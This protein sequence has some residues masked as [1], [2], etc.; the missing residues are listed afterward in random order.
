MRTC[1]FQSRKLDSADVAGTYLATP[2]VR[3]LVVSK[4]GS[5]QNYDRL[6]LQGINLQDGH[7]EDASFIAADLSGATL[8]KANLCRA[9]LVQTQL[10]H[11]D[12]TS[13]CLTGAYIQDWAIATDTKLEQVEANTSTRDCRQKTIPILVVNQITNRKTLNLE[14]FL[15]LLHQSSKLSIFI[16]SKTSIRVLLRLRRLTYTII[17]ESILMQLRLR[18]SN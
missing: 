14:T 16:A 15:I 7:L 2:K 4:D 3:Q 6:A 8:Q 11:A 13:A 9:K 17:K 10:Y 5:N 1:W 18:Y 12:L